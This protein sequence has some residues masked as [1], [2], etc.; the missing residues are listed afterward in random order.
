MLNVWFQTSLFLQC[1][2]L[3]IMLNVQWYT[4][5]LELFQLDNATREPEGDHRMLP[6]S[7]R[8]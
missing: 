6:L 8:L 7:S 2:A 4:R 3:T 1:S 5:T